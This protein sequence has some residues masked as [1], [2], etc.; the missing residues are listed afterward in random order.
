[1]SPTFSEITH[2]W[3]NKRCKKSAKGPKRRAGR[4]MLSLSLFEWLPFGGHVEKMWVSS[5]FT[6]WLRIGGR[7]QRMVF[8]EQRFSQRRRRER[9][10]WKEPERERESGWL[11][12]WAIRGSAKLRLAKWGLNRVHNL[13]VHFIHLSASA[14]RCALPKCFPLLSFLHFRFRSGS[15]VCEC[16]RVRVWVSA[17]AVSSSVYR[18]NDKH[19][20]Q[21]TL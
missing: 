9:G 14:Q 8:P 3:Q 10:K 15:L 17:G 4:G 7:G 5:G 12:E 21:L 20:W 2:K 18:Y 16:A 6:H 1:M 13:A 11:Y 19:L